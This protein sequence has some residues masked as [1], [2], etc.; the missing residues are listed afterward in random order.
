MS[1]RRTLKIT[2]EVPAKEGLSALQ[3]AWE[4]LFWDQVNQTICYDEA[5]ECKRLQAV[6]VEHDG[7]VV[8]SAEVVK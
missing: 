1:A 3:Q 7:T 6:I 8:S 4:L 5:L 2:V